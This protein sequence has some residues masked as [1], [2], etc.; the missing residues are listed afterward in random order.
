MVYLFGNYFLT[1]LREVGDKMDITFR[2][3]VGR[4]NYRV[5]GLLIHDQKLLIMKDENSPY[6]YLPGGRVSMNELS[7][8]AIVREIKEEIEIDV[9]VDRLLWTVENFFIEEQSGDNFHELGLYYLL[10]LTDEQV[11][12]KGSEFMMT[13][14]GKHQLTFYWKPLEELKD[15]YLYPLFIKERILNLPSHPEH[16]IEI[17]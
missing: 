14:G 16:L 5:A 17:K 12:M 7:T 6:Y 1:L 3:E 9:E 8:A 13:E 10:R 15:L 11:L 4:F 2:T